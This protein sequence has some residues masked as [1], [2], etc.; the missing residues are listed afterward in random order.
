MRINTSGA[1][2]YRQE[3]YND[4]A[5]ALGQGTR[6]GGLDEAARFALAMLGDPGRAGDR[7]VLERALEHPDMT[8]ELAELLSTPQVRLRYDVVE[9]REVEVA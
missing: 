5:E 8:P 3:L 2:S 9:E 6:S 7:G 1:Q 4:A